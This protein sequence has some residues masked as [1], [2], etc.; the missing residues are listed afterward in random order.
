MILSSICH[1]NVDHCQQRCH[2]QF[3]MVCADTEIGLGLDSENNNIRICITSGVAEIK[4]ITK[5]DF[6]FFFNLPKSRVGGFDKNYLSKNSGLRVLGS[7]ILPDSV[8]YWIFDHKN[9]HGS[10]I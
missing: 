1:V 9:F 8:K 7:L 10:V 2:L 4:K 3:T 5:K 6:N